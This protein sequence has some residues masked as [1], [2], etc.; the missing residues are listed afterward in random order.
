MAT[1]ERTTT[2]YPTNATEAAGFIPRSPTDDA[3]QLAEWI[4]EHIR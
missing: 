1:S 3:P 4:R 2:D